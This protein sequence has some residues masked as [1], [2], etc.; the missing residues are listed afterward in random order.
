MFLYICNNLSLLEE[1]LNILIT[2]CAGFIGSTLTER[3]IKEHS[4][5]GVDTFDDYYSKNIKENNMNAFRDHANFTF[6]EYD[7]RD[8]NILHQ[9]F[10]KHQIDTVIHFAAKPG[11]RASFGNSAECVS[12][13]IEGTVNLLECMRQFGVKKLVFAS[14]S[15]VY[16]KSNEQIFKET[17]KIGP[18]LSPYAQSKKSCEEYIRSYSAKFGISSVVLRFFTVFGPRQRPDLAICK[19][20]NAIKNG[21]TI[22][23]NGDG[24]S[25]RDYVY[26]DNIIDAIVS[27]ISYDKTLFEIINVGSGESITLNNLVECLEKEIGKPAKVVHLDGVQDGNDQVCADITKAESLLNYKPVVSFREGLHKYIKQAF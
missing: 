12:V 11:I 23:L 16:E 2:G 3:L 6:Y 17:I 27:A 21:E 4:V 26:I 18:S 8:I 19:F 15:A 20:A 14:S 5:I 7:I 13:N 25:T 10:T 22:Y 9:L 24:S 1:S